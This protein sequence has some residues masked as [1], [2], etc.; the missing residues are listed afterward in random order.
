[1]LTYVFRTVLVINRGGCGL[2]SRG[3]STT[4]QTP[5]RWAGMTRTTWT[6]PTNSGSRWT[7]RNNGCSDVGG[8]ELPSGN[9]TKEEQLFRK[10]FWSAVQ[11]PMPTENN[12]IS[13]LLSEAFGKQ[14]ISKLGKS[15]HFKA[16][17]Y[18]RPK[19]LGKSVACTHCVEKV[20]RSTR[21]SFR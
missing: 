8:H 4:A 3:G 15:W 10:S 14:A 5:A 13:P 19:L 11:P 1:M 17:T 9:D 7:I 16:L 12:H 18:N 6:G 2:T 20:N 21:Y